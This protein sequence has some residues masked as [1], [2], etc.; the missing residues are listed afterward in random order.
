MP[1]ADTSSTCAVV[2]KS[3]AIKLNHTIVHSNDKRAAAGFFVDL[4]GLP[5]PVPFGPEPALVHYEALRERG[6][7]HYL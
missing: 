4:F 7:P 6:E 3:M 5:E 2:S 1:P